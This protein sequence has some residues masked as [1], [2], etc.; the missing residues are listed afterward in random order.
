MKLTEFHGKIKHN[1]RPLVVDFW[2][3]WCTPCKVMKPALSQVEKQY[4]GKVD[5][6]KVNIDESAEVAKELHIMSIPTLVG[7][8]EGKEIL[9]RTGVQTQ[10]MLGAFFEATSN[11]EKPAIMPQAPATRLWRT[12]LGLGVLV[13]G[14]YFD[15]SI[16]LMVLGGLI[17]FSGYY[18]RCPIMKFLFPKI[19]GV[20][21]SPTKTAGE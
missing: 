4:A 1:R 20:F 14:W 6:L 10:G 12:V 7:F 11:Q 17:V 16:W 19:K 21:K 5:V 13:L 8:A 15:R 3:P 18:D 9:R 2:A